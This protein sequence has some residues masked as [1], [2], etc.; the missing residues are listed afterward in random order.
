MG[1]LGFLST[2]T[3]MP[4]ASVWVSGGREITAMGDL[5]VGDLCFVFKVSRGKEVGELAVG[6]LDLSFVSDASVF[7]SW[8][9]TC[10]R[11]A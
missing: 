5:A 2:G 1:D 9:C 10:D 8:S 6:D 11:P 3:D 4:T 7:W